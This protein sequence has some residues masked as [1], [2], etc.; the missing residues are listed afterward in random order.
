MGR[1]GSTAKEG[2]S[3]VGVGGERKGKLKRDGGKEEWTDKVT[4]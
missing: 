3:G 1:I 2:L 4:G